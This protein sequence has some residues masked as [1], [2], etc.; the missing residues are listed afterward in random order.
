MPFYATPG[1]DAGHSS[2]YTRRAY[3][4]ITIESLRPVFDKV[5]VAVATKFDHDFVTS[6]YNATLFDVLKYKTDI[7]R[8]SRLG[9]ATVYLTQQALLRDPRWVDVK[10]IFYTESD[11]ILRI[12]HPATLIHVVRGSDTFLI[13]HRIQPVP[14]LQDFGETKVEQD[15]F[16]ARHLSYEHLQEFARN[17]KPVERINNTL[18]DRACCFD[19]NPCSSNRAHWR[20]L[21]HPDLSFFQIATSHRFNHNDSFVLVAG[22][23]NFLRQSFRRCVLGEPRVC[24]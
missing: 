11:Q 14:K 24:P 4:K 1:G 3:L 7:F 2:L 23:G 18:A 15:Q 10:Y 8:P 12:R 20:P 21:T 16:R 9:F 6:T 19:R 22:E 17:N 13:P 5:V